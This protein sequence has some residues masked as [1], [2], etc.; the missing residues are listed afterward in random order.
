MGL[1]VRTAQS[2]LLPRLDSIIVLST[3]TSLTQAFGSRDH[4]WYGFF[5]LTWT[6]HWRVSIAFWRARSTTGPREQ[7]PV[8]GGQTLGILRTVRVMV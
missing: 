8:S 2:S 7:G 5:P 6:G 4:P 3:S 1:G